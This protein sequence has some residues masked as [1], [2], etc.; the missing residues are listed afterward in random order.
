MSNK[1]NKNNNTNIFKLLDALNNKKKF[2]YYQQLTE[3]E[4]KQIVPHLLVKWMVSSNDEFQI[5]ALNEFV[6]PYA[7]SLYEHQELLWKAITSCG[8]GQF[9][10]YNWFKRPSNKRT[11]RSETI[12]AIKQYYEVDNRESDRL[13]H[14]M[15]LNQVIEVAEMVGCTDEQIKQIVKEN[16]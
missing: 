2:E 6:N 15:T 4:K 10:R 16:K 7:F 5:L 12:T 11:K 14:K 13:Y 8:T 3:Q 9:E 1:T